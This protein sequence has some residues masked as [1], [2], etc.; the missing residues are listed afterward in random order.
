MTNNHAC[1][2][3][4]G[5]APDAGMLINERWL[6]DLALHN[7]QRHYLLVGTLDNL[8]DFLAA[9]GARLHWPR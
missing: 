4:A 8:S 6:L 9:L 7:L 3:I 1:R 2:V 5:I